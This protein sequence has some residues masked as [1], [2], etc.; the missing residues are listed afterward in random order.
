[1]L[2]SGFFICKNWVCEI[3]RHWKLLYFEQCLNIGGVSS[4]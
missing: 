2:T 4:A 3:Y 1:M